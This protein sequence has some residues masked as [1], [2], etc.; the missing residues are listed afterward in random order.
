[1]GGI[2]ASNEIT[3]YMHCVQCIA[4]KPGDISPRDWAR[5]EMGWTP[6]GFQVWC[7][8]HDLN[9]LHVD[10]EGQQHPANTNAFDPDP[11]TTMN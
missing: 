10:F 8:R 7:T 1:M 4:E 6:A 2:K 9:V 5:L 11:A 3:A